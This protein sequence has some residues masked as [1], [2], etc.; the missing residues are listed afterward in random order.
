MLWNT[1]N[2]EDVKGS[3]AGVRVTEVKGAEVRVVVVAA[4][5]SGGAKSVL[6]AV[7]LGVD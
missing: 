5:V 4:A 2:D 6:G 1:G 3:T 7:V